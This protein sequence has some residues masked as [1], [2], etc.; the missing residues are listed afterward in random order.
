MGHQTVVYG[1]VIGAHLGF[2][3]DRH[4]LHHENVRAIE[5][6]PIED[7]WPPLVRSMFTVT[8]GFYKSQ[9]IHFGASFKELEWSWELWLDK[10]ET[11][12]ASLFWDDV[13][14]HLVTEAVGEWTYQ[15][16]LLDT[17]YDAW[18]SEPP[19]QPSAWALEGG[20]RDF[21]DGVNAAPEREEMTWE[22]RHA[23]WVRR[24]G[25]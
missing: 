2:H 23:I 10:L 8:D 11:L 20:P 24:V 25:A 15:Y 22:R 9:A 17:P 16:T 14:L 12:L 4:R 7:D 19:S 3:A 6:L 18:A 5:A 21:G 13:R 1:V